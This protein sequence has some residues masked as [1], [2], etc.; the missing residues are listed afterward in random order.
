MPTDGFERAA[1]QGRA[2]R[3]VT[4]RAI[5]PW[6]VRLADLPEDADVLEIGCGIG[7]NAEAFCD[8]YPD[9]RY[10]ATDVDAQMVE[11]AGEL[12]ERFG[13]RVTLRTCDANDLPFADDTFDIALAIGVWHHVGAWEHAL[14]GC[15]RVLR[16]GGLLVL[17]DLLPSFFTG[18]L[19]RM[20][21]PVRTYTLSEMR[22]Q[23]GAAGFAR[24]RVK[25]AGSLW[26]RLVAETPRDG[27]GAM[28]LD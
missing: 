6:V 9:W 13:Q 7:A 20:F 15:V 17:V 23:L 16:P 21:P 2:W 24:F 19:G 8:R 28:E 3:V 1:L 5:M 26:Y 12:L 18:P 14:A 10:T 27:E 4:Q 25:A 11:R 22:A